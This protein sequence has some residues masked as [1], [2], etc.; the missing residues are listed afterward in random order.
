MQQQNQ[1]ERRK[2]ARR[3][4]ERDAQQVMGEQPHG[5][6]DDE[7]LQEPETVPNFLTAREL[8]ARDPVKDE[9]RRREERRKN[10]LGAREREA[11]AREREG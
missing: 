2:E 1:P 11:G 9:E 7:S 8:Q 5:D 4:S 6:E 10:T 3:S